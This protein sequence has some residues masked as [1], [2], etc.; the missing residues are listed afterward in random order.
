MNYELSLV[1]AR[2]LLALVTVLTALCV[3]MASYAGLYAPYRQ[4]WRLLVPESSAGTLTLPAGLE[5]MTRMAATPSIDAPGA[6]PVAGALYQA[7]GP[8]R[9][10]GV[11]AGGRPELEDARALATVDQWLAQVGGR[12]DGYDRAPTVQLGLYTMLS[13]LGILALFFAFLH[14][15]RVVH[16]RRSGGPLPALIGGLGL[17]QV[18]LPEELQR[19]SAAVSVDASWHTSLD[20]VAGIDEAKREVTEVIDF[21]RAPEAFRA[22]GA[23]I[24]RGVILHGPPGNG[25][26]LLARAI[27]SEAHVPFLARPG[28]EFVEAL[29]GVGARR[30]RDLFK[31][32]R[33]AAQRA[34]GRAVVFIDEADSIG[35]RR[36]GLSSGHQENDQTL[37]QLLHEMDG[38]TPNDGIVLIGA[39]NRLDI[40][41]PAV[42]RPGRFTRHVHVPQPDVRARRA[43]LEVRKAQRPFVT[44]IDWDALARRTGGFSGADLENLLNEAAILTARRRGVAIVLDDVNEAFVK[45]LAGPQ[46]PRELTPQARRRVAYHEVGHA[47]VQRVLRGAGTVES[48]SII[49]RGQALGLTVANQDDHDLPTEDQLYATLAMTIGGRVGEDL[50]TGSRST[51]ASD[52]LRKAHDMAERMVCEWGMGERSG[53]RRGIALHPADEYGRREQPASVGAEMEAIVERAYGVAERILSDGHQHIERLVG[54]LLDVE[55]LNAPEIEELLASVGPLAAPPVLPGACAAKN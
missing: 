27:A 9:A 26:T 5:S 2:T 18:G 43:I 16:A 30:V 14:E 10:A 40:L 23:K 36:S 7:E 50:C 15:R 25:K 11:M 8:L 39:T 32:A 4:T 34:E 21:L 47:L 31:E 51:G 1:K 45:V 52:D 46:A 28:S 44:D 35:R 22:V 53:S 29:V 42:L 38:L 19:S 13:L 24:P 49:A 3:G 41:D 37:N 54:E 48:I 33:E 17:R 20:E 6:G 12:I 55:T